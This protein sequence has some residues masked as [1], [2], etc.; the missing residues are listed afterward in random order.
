MRAACTITVRMKSRRLPSKA[1]APL[2]GKPMIEHLIQ[3]L[4]CAKEPADII[5][6]TSTNPQDDILKN[7]AQLCGVKCYRGSEDDVLKRLLDAADTEQADFLVSTTGDNPLTD[8]HYVDKIIL[9]FKET[10]ADYITCLGLPLGA[11][12]YGVNV[13]ALRRVV[14][15]KKEIDTEIWGAYFSESGSFRAV[16][17]DVEE[18]LKRP[19]LRLTVDT[20]EDLRLMQLV[21]GSL[22]RDGAVFELRDVIRLLD[23]HPDWKEINKHVQQRKAPSLGTAEQNRMNHG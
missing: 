18:D 12:S 7:I 13:E 16:E 2:Q 22:Y 11:F 21:F 20:E 9:K 23:S 6:C 4:K 3:R 5:I 10:G 8:P 17:L 15:S 1:I 19:E 14:L